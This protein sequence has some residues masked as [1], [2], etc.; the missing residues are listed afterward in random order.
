MENIRRRHICTSLLVSNCSRA[1]PQKTLVDVY[2]DSRAKS[3][4]LAIQARRAEREI[5]R[6][7]E[8]K[9]VTNGH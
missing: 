4:A 7:E 5:A 1:W 3:V 9:R 2:E 6:E 8:T